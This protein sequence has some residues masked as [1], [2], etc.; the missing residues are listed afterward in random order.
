MIQIFRP[1]YNGVPYHCAINVFDDR[2]MINEDEVIIK[3]KNYF[4]RA[5][6]YAEPAK[7]GS[8]AYGGTILYEGSNS[9]DP[10]FNTPIKL[11]DRDMRLENSYMKEE[12][13]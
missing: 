12:T 11:H 10:R 5:Y 7:E 13:A 3:V 2:E 6:I 8:Y 4:G 1:S 9:H